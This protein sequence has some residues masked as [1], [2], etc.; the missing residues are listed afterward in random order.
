[1]YQA[2]HHVLPRVMKKMNNNVTAMCEGA[3]E[4]KGRCSSIL[5][6]P[7]LFWKEV[8]GKQGMARVCFLN[9]HSE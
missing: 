4:A 3:S 1:M 2:N 5:G 8:E 9:H 6:G 7:E